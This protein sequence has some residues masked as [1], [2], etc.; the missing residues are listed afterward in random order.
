MFT[1]DHFSFSFMPFNGE[2]APFILSVAMHMFAC[3]FS[4]GLTNSAPGEGG[5]VAGYERCPAASGG[6]GRG[7]CGV[8]ISVAQGPGSMFAGIF[9]EVGCQCCCS[10]ILYTCGVSNAIPF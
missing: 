8:G 5:P 2:V 7:V 3:F 10:H 1:W 4:A 9:D 6:A